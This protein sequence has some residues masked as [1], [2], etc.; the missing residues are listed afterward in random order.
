MDEEEAQGPRGNLGKEKT[1]LALI[2][3]ANPLLKTER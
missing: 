1:H 2:P 3:S